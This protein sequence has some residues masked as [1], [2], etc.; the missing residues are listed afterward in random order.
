MLIIRQTQ[1]CNE[2]LT[3]VFIGFDENLKQPPPG[4]GARWSQT[5]KCWFVYYHQPRFANRL[6]DDGTDLRFPQLLPGHSRLK[7][8]TFHTH[9]TKR[10]SLD[11]LID[12]NSKKKNDQN[13]QK[14]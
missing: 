4:T 13:Q 7:A 5:Q 9:L 8:T 11:R 10:K 6:A 2:N 1:H 3:I 14:G 12:I